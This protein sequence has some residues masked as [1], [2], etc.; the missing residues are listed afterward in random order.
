M[1]DKIQLPQHVIDLE[2][3]SQDVSYGEVGPFYLKRSD[4]KTVGLRGQTNKDIRFRNSDEAL[5]Y[6][7]DA[8]KSLP[9]DK[10]GEVTLKLQFK[11]GVVKQITNTSDMT[12][13]YS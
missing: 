2:R 4:G 1:N 3:L 8:V 10:S 6:I 13:K 11:D 12:T 7:V 9:A 5:I